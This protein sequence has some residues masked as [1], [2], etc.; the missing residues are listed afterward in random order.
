MSGIP[1]AV[2]LSTSCPSAARSPSAATRAA[3]GSKSARNAWS[4]YSARTKRLTAASQSCVLLDPVRVALGL[5]QRLL[6]VRLD[7]LGA[8]SATP[9]PASGTGSSARRRRAR[10]RGAAGRSARTSA[11]T[12]A[13]H[14]SGIDDSAP[15]RA[16]T[17]AERLASW[18][19]VVSRFSG[20]RSRALDAAG[21]E[22]RRRRSRSATGRPRRRSERA[23]GSSGR[24]RCPRRPWP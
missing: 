20:K 14:S 5:A 19:C 9:R 21:V 23:G 6:H 10:R 8:R 1:G 12:C 11:S 2:S 4:E 13:A 7:P 3:N 24:T 15:I 16:R 22:A 17:S 18:V